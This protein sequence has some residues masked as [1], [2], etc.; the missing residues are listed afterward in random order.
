LLLGDDGGA[1]LVALREQVEEQLAR[2]VLSSS[3]WE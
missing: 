2:V 1:P 3:L